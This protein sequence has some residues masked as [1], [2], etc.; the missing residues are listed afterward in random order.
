MATYGYS[1]DEARRFLEREL[2]QV[3]ASTS[4]YW[5]SE[6][7]EEL[8]D[9]LVGVISKLLAANN[10]KVAEDMQREWQRGSRR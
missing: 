6:E 4:F 1:E 9:L 8:L 3:A 7:T 5:E 2:R 10:K